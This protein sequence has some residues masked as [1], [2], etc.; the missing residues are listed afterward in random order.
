[1]NRHSPEFK[2]L[3]ARLQSGEL[4]RAQ[5]CDIYGLQR[6]TLSTWLTRSKVGASTRTKTRPLAGSAKQF[7]ESM[8]PQY[9]LLLNDLVAKVLS[10]EY[11]SCRAAH[12]ANPQVPLSTLTVRVRKARKAQE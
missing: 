9:V 11:R 2:E 5:A 8:D 6:D 10:G 1:M 7:V 12:L 3:V 4:T